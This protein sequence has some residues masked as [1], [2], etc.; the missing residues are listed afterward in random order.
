MDQDLAM[1]LKGNCIMLIDRLKHLAAGAA[2][3]L[4]V[5]T[6]G[7]MSAQAAG[8]QE[9]IDDNNTPA[10]Q[11][12]ILDDSDAILYHGTEAATYAVCN[13]D[14][15]E[16]NVTVNYDENS[17]DLAPGNC[18]HVNAAMIR[19]NGTKGAKTH[20]TSHRVGD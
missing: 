1:H 16:G 17:A 15:G 11:A 10:A 7:T 5:S 19:V 13:D 6:V 8:G 18:M 9:R 12:Y 20:V 2:A 3:V 14:Q 4:L